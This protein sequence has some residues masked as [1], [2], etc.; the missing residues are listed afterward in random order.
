[1]AAKNE[2]KKTFEEKM[3]RLDEIV[4]IMDSNELPLDETLKLYEEAQVLIKDL[5]KELKE[6]KTKVAKYVE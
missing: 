4:V 1:M 2:N 3:K 5:E 6:A